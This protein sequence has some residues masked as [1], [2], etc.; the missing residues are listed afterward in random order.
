MMTRVSSIVLAIALA[1]AS[2]TLAV[3]CNPGEGSVRKAVEKK[4]L[5]K[6]K[7]FK[8]TS[9]PRENR[10]G[11]IHYNF[12]GTLQCSKR[13][14]H[15]KKFPGKVPITGEATMYGVYFGLMHRLQKYQFFRDDQ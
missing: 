14:Y 6:I 8:F 1:L 5:C 9:K 10:D 11:S 7:D 4:S 15:Y 12:M 2:A 13:S 3:G